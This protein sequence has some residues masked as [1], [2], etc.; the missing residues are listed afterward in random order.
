MNE[1]R[2]YLKE[3]LKDPEFKKE[4]D[5]LQPEME[6]IRKE[7]EERKAEQHPTNA[8][9]QVLFLYAKNITAQYKRQKANQNLLSFLVCI[10]I[11]RLATAH[12]LQYNTR[13]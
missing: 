9:C 5:S 4:W 10:N 8:N 7:I 13:N 6:I 3:Q 1:F 11:A 12:L 2:E